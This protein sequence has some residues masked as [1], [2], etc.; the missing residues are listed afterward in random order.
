MHFVLCKSVNCVG[1]LRAYTLRNT[2]CLWTISGTD[3]GKKEKNLELFQLNK[4][5]KYR[6]M[7][8]I[9]RVRRV[10]WETIS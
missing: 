8:F 4:V 9:R 1:L 7:Q 3:E 6:H 10:L 5:G 2:C